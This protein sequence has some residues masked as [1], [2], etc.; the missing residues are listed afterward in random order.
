MSAIVTNAKNRIAYT[1]VRSLGGK[2]I[3]V[4]TA[5]FVPLSMSFASR[6]SKGHFI[7]P[8]P[9]RDRAGFIASI[10]QNVRRLE[11]DV[12]IPVFEETFL[13]SKYKDEI[14]RHVRMAVP[15]YDQVLTAHNKDRWMPLAE[16]LGVPVPRTFAAAELRKA[17]PKAAALTYPVLVKPYQGGGAWGIREAATERELE[18]ILSGDTYFGRPWERFSVQEKINGTVHCVAMLFSRG[19]LKAH[20]VYRQLRDLPF[21]GGQATLRVSVDDPVAVGHLRRLLE[22]LAWHGICQADF[23]VDEATGTPYLIDINP[24][25]WGSLVQGIASGVDF[26]Y[27]LYT[28]ARDGDTRRVDGFSKGVVTRWVWGDL[29]TFPEALK[30]AGDRMGFLREY[31]RLFGG[32]IAFDDLSLRDPLPFFTFGLDFLAKMVGQKTLHPR[33]HDSLEGVWE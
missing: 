20:V 32:K 9:F 31:F 17:G 3:P 27:L 8:S 5:D 19:E 4:Y 24:R 30:S 28:L 12:L 25:L 10:V 14:T 23:I 16:S 11:A 2:G 21:T 7:Y 1:V 26:P 22:R 33:S 6:F 18:S 15:D 13:L 29:R